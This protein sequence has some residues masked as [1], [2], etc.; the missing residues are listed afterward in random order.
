[1]P[2]NSEIRRKNQ[3][4]N[5]KNRILLFMKEEKRSIP[6]RE[7]K[8]NSRAT[9]PFTFFPPWKRVQ[10]T[11]RKFDSG[12]HFCARGAIYALLSREIL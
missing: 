5:R 8:R 12:V 11:R 10:S 2:V 3:K 6:T 7:Q 9:T 1:M 4:R